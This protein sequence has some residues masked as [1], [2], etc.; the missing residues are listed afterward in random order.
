MQAGLSAGHETGGTGRKGEAESRRKYEYI[1][2]VSPSEEWEEERNRPDLQTGADQKL[3]VPTV[4][5]FCE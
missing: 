1:K 4:F 2:S 3:C 5:S